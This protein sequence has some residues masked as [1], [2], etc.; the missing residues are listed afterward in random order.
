MPSA[1]PMIQALLAALVLVPVA[2]AQ[3][4]APAPPEALLAPGPFWVGFQSTWALDEGRSYR[5]AY[6]EGKTYGA[7]KAPRPLLV[8]LWYPAEAAGG[9]TEPM[10]HGR[11]FSVS[12]ADARLAPYADALGAY[13]RGVFVEQVMG[14]PEGALDE[15]ERGEL[16]AALAAPTLCRPGV[17]PAPGP[18]PLVVYHSGAGSSFEDN[19]ALCEHLASHGY[20]VL[21]SAFPHADGSSL[22]IDAARGSA[23]DV[24]FLVRWARALPFVDWRHV[25]LA[26][27]SAGAQA[28]LKYAAQPGCVGDALVL[29]DTTQDYYGLAMPVHESLVREATEGVLQLTRPL[30]V[31]AGPEALFALCDSLVHAERTYLTVPELGHDEFISQG[32]QRLERIGRAFAAGR[33]GADAAEVARTP[34]V[35]ANYR[36][37]CALV[38]SFLDAELGRGCAEFAARLE[39][40]RALPWSHAVPRLVRVP[41]GVSAPEPYDPESDAPP[42][43]RQ[44]RVVLENE[45]V[46]SACAVLER[47]RLLEPR[48]PLY[49][50]TMLAGSLLYG[51]LDRGRRDEAELYYSAL[52]GISLPVLSL[53]EFLADMAT[54]QG[55][56]E[57]ALHFLRLAHDLDPEHA[58]VANKLRELEDQHAR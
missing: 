8:L 47:F 18:F 10:P 45:G 31:A 19:A 7:E 11:Y 16:E 56:S 52:Q 51:L 44:F 48:G 20:V 42:T 25:A 41:R 9:G 6:D 21:G 57:Q 3:S 24:Q 35:R 53:F 38:R 50:S 46:A 4:E 5:T 49:T 43:P 17:E 27:H 29:L 12:S 14:E 34:T 37:L 32:L 26:G 54:L 40:E 23:E 1:V 13:A 39:R 30:L 36:A 15:A 22:G 2:L 28:M 58:A 55:K 33:A